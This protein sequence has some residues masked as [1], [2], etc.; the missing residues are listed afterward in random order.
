MCQQF[1]GRG[2]QW[3]WH[4]PGQQVVYVMLDL[5]KRGQDVRA[6]VQALEGWV[7]ACLD[8]FGIAGDR[9]P[10]LPGIWVAAGNSV[11]AMTRWL[12]LASGSA[13]GS[14]GTDWR[15]ILTRI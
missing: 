7:I 15:S 8:D 12:Q 4:G 5:A 6:L 9:R 3:T 11:A 2:G 13:V 10:G 14:A 1:T